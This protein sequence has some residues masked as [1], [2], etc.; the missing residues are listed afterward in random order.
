MC[1]KIGVF[2]S[3]RTNLPAPYRQAAEEGGG[4]IGCTGRTLVYGGARK[5]LMEV[6]ARAVKES[7]GRVYG[8]VPQIIEERGQ[9]S[10]VPDVLFR[11]ADLN[12]RKAVM[13]RESDALLVLPGGIGTLD[14]AFTVL[15]AGLI[16][17]ARK[18]LVFYNVGGC[19]DALLAM[20]AGMQA[21]GLVD[22]GGEPLWR[23][24]TT[25]DELERC[26]GGR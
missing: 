17:I 26:F 25:V 11:T 22:D 9:V 14:E 7:G 24:A 3:S 1:R 2:L 19:W 21:Q 15:A 10:D 4:W 16:G 18:P 5:G 12:D 13:V 8:V 6:L 23:V 20:L